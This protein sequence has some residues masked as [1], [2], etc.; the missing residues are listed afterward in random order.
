MSSLEDPLLRFRSYCHPPSL[1]IDPQNQGCRSAYIHY[2]PP[3]R[4]VSVE[5]PDIRLDNTGEVREVDGWFP[6]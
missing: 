4:S 5:F 2:H 6:G 1:I 3:Q